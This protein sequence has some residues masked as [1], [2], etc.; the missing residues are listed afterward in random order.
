MLEFDGFVIQSK[1]SHSK[2]AMAVN[3]YANLYKIPVKVIKTKDIPKN[4]V[5]VGDVEWCLSYLDKNVV[6][7]YYPPF[8]M[9]HLHRF[10]YKS[11]EWP[12]G[13][14]VFIKPADKYKRFTGFVTTGGYRKKKRG[15]YWCSDVVNFINEWRYYVSN[16]EILTAEWYYGDEINT[17]PAPKLEIEIPKNYCGAIDFGILD[18]GE[19][20]L[21]EANHPFACG[22]YGKNHDVYAKWLVNG[23]KYMI[24]ESFV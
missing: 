12:L 6:P 9:N 24:N 20:A 17:P 16:G 23:W 13:K 4:C 19:L 7:D 11:D 2:E 1:E 8:L 22:W 10:V 21:V 5:P 14:K 15:P 18:N 3:W